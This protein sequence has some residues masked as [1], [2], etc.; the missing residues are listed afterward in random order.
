MTFPRVQRHQIG[1]DQAQSYTLPDTPPVTVRLSRRLLLTA[2]LTGLGPLPRVVAGPARLRVGFVNPGRTSDRFWQ[3][4][5][6]AIL[7]AANHFNIEII[8]EI[9]ERDRHRIISAGREILTRQ[10]DYMLIVNEHR[11]AVP[12]MNASLAAGIPSMLVFSGMAAEDA[13]VLGRPRERSPLFL[14]SLLADNAGAGALMARALLADCRRLHG[15]DG[16]VPLL[17]LGGVAATPAGQER[18]NGLHQV[19]AADGGA[20]L[21]DSV[22]VNWSREEARERAVSLLRRQPQTRGIWCASDDMA[23]GALDALTS[24]GMEAGRDVS[25][26]G[27]NWQEDALREVAAG[28]MVLSMGGHF[29]LGAWALAMLRDLADG[30]DFAAAGGTEQ[31]L[32]MAPLRREQ[33]GAYLAR[34]GGDGWTRIDFNR[35]RQRKGRYNLTVGSVLTV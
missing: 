15:T 20:Q 19:L 17:A 11:T 9:T 2:A 26:T 7:T 35:L 18:M 10:P 14:G 34:F 4:A 29:L 22:S 13:A 33:V 21:L 24:L 31:Y 27:L 28:H 3:M 8:T 12:L 32:S 16:P 30:K 6:Q 23:L 5:H 25:V 1:Y